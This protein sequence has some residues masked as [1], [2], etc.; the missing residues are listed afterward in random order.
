MALLLNPKT[1]QFADG[2]CFFEVVTCYNFDKELKILLFSAIQT[3]EIAV[4]AK[5]IKY[6]SQ[7]SGLFWFMDVANS[8]NT[9]HFLS[10]LTRVR[11]EVVRF[12]ES[13][14]KEHFHKYDNPDFPPV[15]KTSPTTI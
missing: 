5:V 14:I 10:N 9:D 11:T 3:I 1:H 12:K 4:R 2:S 13:Y 8:I 7:T 6:F 15:W